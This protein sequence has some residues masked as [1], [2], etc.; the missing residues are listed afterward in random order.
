MWNE[1]SWPTLKVASQYLHE[2][3]VEN[4][5]NPKPGHPDSR[6]CDLS[7]G[8]D[9]RWFYICVGLNIIFP[10]F[11]FKIMFSSRTAQ[12]KRIC[13]SVGP[14]TKLVGMAKTLLHFECD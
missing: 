14:G 12:T 13:K 11:G 4:Y 5:R 1:R 9:R 7:P 10:E 6:L 8:Y 2:G 3:T